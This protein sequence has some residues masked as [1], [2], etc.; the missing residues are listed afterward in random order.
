MSKI[1]V[2]ADAHD[3]LAKYARKFRTIQEAAKSLGVSGPF[4]GDCLKGRR[5]VSPRLLRQ[6][7]LKRVIAKTVEIPPSPA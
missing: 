5:D 6:L 3:E 2:L 4:L 7:G 1:L